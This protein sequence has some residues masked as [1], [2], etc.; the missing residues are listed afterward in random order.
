M[1]IP[2]LKKD[3]LHILI[4]PLTVLALFLPLSLYEFLSTDASIYLDIG[5]NIFRG[6]GF[7]TSCNT[8]QYWLGKY[9]P[10][11][12]YHQNIYPLLAGLIWW[13]TSS[14][15]A[16]IIGNII[17]AAVNSILLFSFLSKIYNKD[18][19]FYGAF[20]ASISFSMIHTASY[21]WTEQLY[22]LIL[23]FSL[24]ILL[25]RY[26]IKKRALLTGLLMGLATLTRAANIFCA[27]AI[28]IFLIIYTFEEERN[29]RLIQISLFITGTALVLG[30]YELIC[31]AAFGT[32]YP[33]Y[34]KGAAAFIMGSYLPGGY[35]AQ[36]T[37][38]LRFVPSAIKWFSV[39]SISNVINHLA[40]FYKETNLLALS[41]GLFMAR[42]VMKRWKTHKGET[43]TLLLIGINVIGHS[44]VLYS[45]NVIGIDRF[46]IIP[47][48][49]GI[50]L[51][52]AGLYK[53]LSC[54]KSLTAY[55]K[56]IFTSIMILSLILSAQRWVRNDITTI[57]NFIKKGRVNISDKEIVDW[58]N[59]NSSKDDLLATNLIEYGFL[60][61]RP[62]VSLPP[63]KVLSYNN[64]NKFLT[65]FKPDI[66]I[67]SPT[68]AWQRKYFDQ[69]VS[70]G[71]T[72]DIINS[73]S[74]QAV[75]FKRI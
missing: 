17:I 15:R 41:S 12:P 75:V 33:E 16:V 22:L 56:R 10:S 72:S 21:P 63:D 68:E 28:L 67:L 45:M 47:E 3:N 65:M 43:L 50:P 7:Y 9:Y 54:C 2:I 58:I 44:S 61:D 29:G 73:N 66:I 70:R 14:I 31:F 52:C 39:T 24:N 49:M 37:P 57:N 5:R 1:E 64:L 4:I 11:L 26:P 71:Y 55:K 38:I 8:Y 6:K 62:L 46:I 32:F 42:H 30:V 74:Y 60:Y 53:G 35:Y 34:K 27:A 36:K 69:I 25:G 18:I 13:L 20:L 40:A 51:C 19:A 48:I 23:L 59:K